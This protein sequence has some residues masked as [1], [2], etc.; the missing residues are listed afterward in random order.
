MLE[1]LPTYSTMQL[2]TRIPAL[3]SVFCFGVTSIWAVE[4]DED[5]F[6]LHWLESPYQAKETSL[7][8][9]LPD[10]MEVGKRYRVLYVLPVHEDGL[11]NHGDGLIEVKKHNY[12]N[13][14]QLICVAPAFT[15]K[16]WFADNDL[17]PQKQDERHFLKTV[18]PFVDDNYPTQANMEG[19]LLYPN[20]CAPSE[21]RRFLW[22][23]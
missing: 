8:V 1:K 19:R 14:H 5:G 20:V 11:K 3:F 4:K 17:N 7:R 23:G 16:P 2:L 10:R 22:G 13:T 21:A 6:L 18:I 12:H 15:T 9:L